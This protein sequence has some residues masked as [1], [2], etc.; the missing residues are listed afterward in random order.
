MA[1]VAQRALDLRI[2]P[3]RIVRRHPHDEL[4]NLEQDTAPSGS[5]AV[6]PLPRDQLTVPPKQGVRR[7]NR[8]DLPQDR[9]ADSVRSGSQPTAI[10]VRE[11]QPTPTKLTPQKPVLFDQVHDGLPF[12]AIQPA[13]QHTEHDL[14]RN[15]VDHW[16]E[17]TS[18]AGV[19]DIGRDVEHYGLGK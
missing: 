18:S 1:N 2:A 13:G 11:T 9:T 6:R 10:L 16:P 15:G 3:R 7:R 8:G 17:L 12:L 5:S 4:T 14:Q 19:N